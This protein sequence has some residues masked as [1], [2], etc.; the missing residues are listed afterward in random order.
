MAGSNN[1]GDQVRDAIQSA[2]ESQDYSNL[3][4]VVEQSIGSATEAIGQSLHQASRAAQSAQLKANYKKASRVG[5]VPGAYPQ[6]VSRPSFISSRNQSGAI[7]ASRYGSTFKDKLIGWALA[8]SGGAA[9]GAFGLSS[10]VCLPVAIIESQPEAYAVVILLL[11]LCGAGGFVLRSGVKRINLINRFRM[12]QSVL[13]ARE[14]CLIEEVSKQASRPAKRVLEDVRKLISKG[15][16]KQGHIDDEGKYLIVTDAA[17]DHYRNQSNL[18]RQR[19]RQQQLD[20][21]RRMQ[22]RVSAG[23]SEAYSILE[24]GEAFVRQIRESND[25]IPGE[26]ISAKI[27][28]IERIV[29]SIFEYAEENPQVIP[30]LDRL[31]DYYLPTTVKLLD[32]Y[33]DLDR[34]PVQGENIQKSKR[35]I[36]QTLDSLNVA[37]TKLLDSIFTEVAWDVTTDVSVLHTVLAQEGL[38]ENPFAKKA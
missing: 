34:Q 33:E 31:M 7:V 25:A 30:D 8:L 5:S 2:I 22:R 9:A 26:E 32:A 3:K 12:Y 20:A 37:F 15:L 38:L 13:A 24:R 36:E 14:Y 6:Q 18:L 19:E 1:M 4:Y 35:E 21:D 16:F 10:L 17:Y 23:S 29:R 11:G 28:Q 27:D